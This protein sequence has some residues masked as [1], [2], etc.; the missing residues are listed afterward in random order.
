MAANISRIPSALTLLVNAVKVY[1][2]HSQTSELFQIFEGFVEYHIMMSC[3]LVMRCK[4]IS[5]S[6][7]SA[8][9]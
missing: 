4:L 3:I 6:T 8:F 9:H 7:F 1:Y 2:Y 5:L